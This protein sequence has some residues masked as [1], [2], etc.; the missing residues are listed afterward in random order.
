MPFSKSTF[1]G[2]PFETDAEQSDHLQSKLNDI[3]KRYPQLT[4]H[5]DNF[6]QPT[7]QR[8]CRLADDQ[9][10]RSR[11]G[12]SLDLFESPF[13]RDLD[14][15]QFTEGFNPYQKYQSRTGYPQNK[16]N[17]R[18]SSPQEQTEG[19]EKEPPSQVHGSFSKFSSSSQIPKKQKPYV[20]QS[21]TIDFDRKQD[22]LEE[23]KER[24]RSTP[25]TEKTEK[26]FAVNPLTEEMSYHLPH[27]ETKSTE[28]IIPI[29]IEGRDTPI[30]PKNIFPSQSQSQQS[31]C[32]PEKIFGQRPE[33]FTK[34]I[35]RDP[36]EFADDWHEFSAEPTK[37]TSF[38]Q[39]NQPSKVSVPNE[40][41]TQRDDIE[42]ESNNS[43]QSTCHEQKCLTPIEQIQVIQKDVSSLMEQVQ[44]F[45]GKSRN[46][47]F[48]YLDEMLTRN[49]IKLDNIDVQ[50]QE[51]IRSSRKE[52]IKCIEKAI[53]ILEA[54]ASLN[55]EDKMDSE[56]PQKTFDDGNEEKPE[57]PQTVSSEP[58]TEKGISENAE[59]EEFEKTGANNK[60][61]NENED[62]PQQVQQLEEK[63]YEA[64]K[65]DEKVDNGNNGKSEKNLNDIQ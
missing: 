54:K 6:T 36:R 18:Y 55:T 20:Q 38:Q 42:A 10:F 59:V 11:F 39:P 64:E 53:G 26:T 3:K 5:L 25:P 46:K 1:S 17:Q 45:T 62:K 65:T 56:H 58:A 4:E 48:L 34:F 43:H 47:Q 7:S 44:Q 9:E 29:Q 19:Q 61:T 15:E 50:G 28:R 8:S 22:L 16:F 31:F 21:N 33:Q 32:G 24:S 41:D 37:A 49:L 30:V 12:R 2:Y 13:S 51:S 35:Q 27:S 57:N 40:H 23:R 52:A 14:S 60:Q 63:V